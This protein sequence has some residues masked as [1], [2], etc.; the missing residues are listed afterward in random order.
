MDGKKSVKGSDAVPSSIENL[1]KKGRV[2]IH[3]Y[4]AI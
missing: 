3:V 2:N 1:I 4:V